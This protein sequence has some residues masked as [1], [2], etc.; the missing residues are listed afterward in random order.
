MRFLQTEKGSMDYYRTELP[1]A[2]STSK[3]K[4]Y[5]ED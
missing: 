1:I 3:E 4:A 5:P 2:S